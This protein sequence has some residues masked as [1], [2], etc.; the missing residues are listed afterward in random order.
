MT[1]ALEQLGPA[2][3]HAEARRTRLDASLCDVEREIERLS[4]AIA[5]GGD[6]AGLL[7]A[8]KAGEDRRETLRAE[9]RSTQGMVERGHVD[10]SLLAVQIRQRVEEWRGLLTRQTSHARQLLRRLVDGPM[11]FTPRIG[12][13]KLWEFRATARLDRLLAWIVDATSVASL[14]V[15]SWNQVLGWLK[16]MDA[17][18]KATQLTA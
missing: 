5:S 17:L 16:E 10:R 13:P 1:L 4:D 2:V 14:S 7:V 8:L 11:V 12:E 6:L 15:P 9:L 18:R 3:E